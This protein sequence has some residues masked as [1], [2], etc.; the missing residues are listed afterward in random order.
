MLRLLQWLFMGHVHHW[1]VIECGTVVDAGKR[2]GRWYDEQ[3]TKCGHRRY[4]Q[5]A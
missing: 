2:V 3:C 4:R 5:D 1:N